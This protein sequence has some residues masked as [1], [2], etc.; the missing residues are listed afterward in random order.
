MHDLTADEVFHEVVVTPRRAYPP[1]PDL[2]EIECDG[3]LQIVTPSSKDGPLNEIIHARLDGDDAAIEAAIDRATGEYISRGLRYRW[4]VGPTETPADL[5]DRLAR[6]GL[7]P[8]PGL[9]MARSTVC[10]P[11]DD[12]GIRIVQVDASNVDTYTEVMTAG[13][14]VDIGPFRELHRAVVAGTRQHLFMAFVDGAPVATG[15]YVAFARSAYLIGAVTLPD[16]RGRGLY[17]ALVEARLA[18]AHAAGLPIA[19]THAR[20]S[21]SAPILAKLGFDTVC[22]FTMMYS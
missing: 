13:W 10:D 17:R 8:S 20:G 3:V 6:R 5:A 15:S 2:V 4:R 18:H 19:T 11:V 12:P 16:Y 21:S 22:T 7:K 14:S 9:G 1:Y